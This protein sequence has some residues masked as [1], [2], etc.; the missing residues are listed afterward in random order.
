M[1]GYLNIEE[2][3]KRLGI[4]QIGVNKAR[5]RGL[6]TGILVAHQTYLYAVEEVERYAK[7]RRKPGRPKQKITN[8]SESTGET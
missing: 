8:Q 7:E 2:T 6:L 1:E 4:T 3:A 5:T